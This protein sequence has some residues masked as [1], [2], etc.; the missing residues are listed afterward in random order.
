MPIPNQMQPMNVQ[1]PAQGQAM[2][3]Q[4]PQQAPQQ[5]APQQAAPSPSAMQALQSKMQDPK[6][7]AWF[8]TLPPE[9]KEKVLQRLSMDYQGQGDIANEQMATAQ[10]LRGTATPEGR[11]AG[12]TYVAA[13]PLEHIA[14]GM[15]QY[16]GK[17]Q[18]DEA[19]ARKKELSDM[20]GKGLQEV[21]ASQLRSG[22]Y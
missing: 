8:N 9:E 6:F 2:G 22:A 4:A 11:Q 15:K 14:S 1:P 12:R 5:Q 10:A 17:Q 16:Q 19:L 13:N 18:M 7:S 20:Q 21:M 3:Q